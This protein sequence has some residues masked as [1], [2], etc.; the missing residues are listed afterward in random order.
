MKNNPRLHNIIL[1]FCR[2]AFLDFC[3]NSEIRHLFVHL[4]SEETGSLHV[5]PNPPDSLSTKS[6]FFLKNSYA[7]RLSKDTISEEVV[8]SECSQNPMEHL[9]LIIREIYLPILADQ[10]ELKVSPE[11]VLDILHRLM[12]IIQVSPVSQSVIVHLYHVFR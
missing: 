11:R 6:L 3:N 4:P 2:L 10:N 1:F 9:E 7:S 5:S 8:C 12:N